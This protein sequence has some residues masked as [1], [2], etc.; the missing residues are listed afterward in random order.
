MKVKEIYLD[1]ILSFK[2]F[3]LELDN[4]KGLTRDVSN[5]GHWWNGS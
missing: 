4:P 5:V 2:N 1:N 3:R